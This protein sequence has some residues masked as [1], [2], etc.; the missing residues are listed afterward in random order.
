[1]PVAWAAFFATRLSPA[2]VLRTVP[3]ADFIAFAVLDFLRFAIFVPL[4]SRFVE[5]GSF[6]HWCQARFG[7]TDM[8]RQLN[9]LSTIVFR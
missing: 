1:M 2:P 8:T 4:D 5:L 7:V 6:L 3:F 9:C